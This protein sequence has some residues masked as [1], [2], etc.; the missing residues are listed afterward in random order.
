[1]HH[2]SYGNCIFFSSCQTKRLD[3]EPIFFLYF[4]SLY[5]EGEEGHRKKVVVKEEEKEKEEKGRRRGREGRGTR[6][7][8]EREKK[9]LARAT[10]T[11]LS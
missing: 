1:M 6:G 9:N 3:S 11:S 7:K 10:N 2:T 8:R 5:T 4:H